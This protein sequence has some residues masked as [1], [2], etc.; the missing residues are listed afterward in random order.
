MVIILSLTQQCM[1]MHHSSR[2]IIQGG[3]EGGQDIRRNFCPEKRFQTKLMLH[4][5]RYVVKLLTA[6]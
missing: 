3:G 6:L 5:R 2:V 4:K 1:H